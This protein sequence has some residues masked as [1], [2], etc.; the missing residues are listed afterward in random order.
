[1]A[2]YNMAA[3]NIKAAKNRFYSIVDN[4]NSHG[5]RGYFSLLICLRCGVPQSV[6]YFAVRLGQLWINLILKQGLNELALWVFCNGAVSPSPTYTRIVL[7]HSPFL[8][9]R[10]GRCY[11]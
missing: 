8:V 11:S 7:Q 4:I 6:K 2:N 9:Q 5:I 1:M 10:Y 3:L